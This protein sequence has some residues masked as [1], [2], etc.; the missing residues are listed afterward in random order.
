MFVK[1]ARINLGRVSI[2]ALNRPEGWGIFDGEQELSISRMKV[3]SFE[4]SNNELGGFDIEAA[5]KEHPDHLFVKVF[6]IKKDEVNDNG[7]AFNEEELKKS[8]ETFIGVPVFCNHQ[9]DDIEKARGKVVHAWY[10]EDKG[11]I[12]TINMVDKVAYPKLARGIEEGY[13]TGTSMGCQVHHSLCSICHTKAHVADEYCSHI[14]ERKTKKHS[15]KVKCAFHKSKCKPEEACPICGTEKGGEAAEIIHKDAVIHEWNYGLKFIEDSFV[16]NPACHDCLVDCILNTPKLEKEAAAINAALTKAAEDSTRVLKVADG[17]LMKIASF[18]GSGP[19]EVK[20]SLVQRINYVIRLANKIA[21]SKETQELLKFAGKAEI[22]SLNKAMKHMEVVAKS[23]MDQ[24]QQVSMEYVSDIVDVLASLQTV[25]DELVEMGYAALPTPPTFQDPETLSDAVPVN[26]QGEQTSPQAMQPA[27]APQPQ[28]QSQPSTSQGP[29]GIGS[30]TKPT[31]SPRASGN[32]KELEKT[33]ANVV[34]QVASLRDVIA[35]QVKGKMEYS[36]TKNN[37]TIVASDNPEGLLVVQ[38]FAGDKLAATVTE[39]LKGI[40]WAENFR[41][42]PDKEALD[43]IRELVANGHV[44][45]Q[46]TKESV[47][48]ADNNTK[49]AAG[50]ALKQEDTQVI[51]EK[52][53]NNSADKLEFAG[54][55]Q[56]KEI[57]TVT[58]GDEQLGL[59]KEPVNDTSSDSP[60]V[61]KG[62]YANVTTENQLPDLGDSPI[63]RWGSAPD[64]ILEKQWRD[65]DRL[66]G[67]EGIDKGDLPYIVTQTQLQQLRDHHRWVEPNFTTENQLASDQNWLKDENAWLNKGA[68]SQYA[69][70]LVEAA[71]NTLSDAIASYKQTPLEVVKAAKF[72]TKDPHSQLKAAFLTLINGSPA[73]IA[74]RQAERARAAYFDKVASASI[75]NTQ[76]VDAL[77]GCM[78][79]NCMYLKAEDLV[80]AVRHVASDP[81][82]MAAV[83]KRAQVKL[84]AK[85][86]PPVDQTVDKFAAMDEAFKSLSNETPVQQD[87]D[88]MYQ[89]RAAAEEIGDPSDEA[90]FILSAERHA[91]GILKSANVPDDTVL[92]SVEFDPES[93]TVLTT[94]KEVAKLSEAEVSALEKTA[95]ARRKLARQ[96]TVKSTQKNAQMMGG[97]MGGGMDGGAGAGGAGATMPPAPGGGAPGQPPMPPAETMSDESGGLDEMGAEEDSGPK[98][99]GAFCPVCGTDDVDVVG[100][101]SKCNNPECGQKYVVKTTIELDGAG[102]G[103]EEGAPGE[104]EGEGFE[105]PE[106]ETGAEEMGAE[107]GA[108]AGAGAGAP[109]IPVAAMT[110]LNPAVLKK[111]ASVKG[112]KLGCFSPITGSNNT[113]E[114]GNGKWLCLSS[115]HTYEVDTRVNKKNVS[116]VWAEWRWNST[117]KL[118]GKECSSCNRARA[119]WAKALSTVKLTSNQ[120]DSMSFKKKAETVLAMHAK[121]AFAVVKTASKNASVI[122]DFQK[123]YA[124]AGAFPMQ[125]C[126]QKLANRF[127]ENALAISGPCKGDKIFDCVC[128]QLKSAG[129]YSDRIAI[130][131]AETWADRDGCIECIEDYVRFGLDMDKAASVCQHLK[132]KYAENEE[133]LAEEM[134]DSGGDD[135]GGDFSSQDEGDDFGDTDPF[136]GGDEESGDDSGSPSATTENGGDD[137]GIEGDEGGEMGGDLGGEGFGGDAGGPP[138]IGGDMGGDQL[139]GGDLGA[140]APGG[141]GLGAPGGGHG[142]V[143]IELPLSAL[144]AIEQAI[145]SAHGE[146]PGAESHH[147]LSGIPGDT[148]VELQLDAPTVDGLEGAAENTLEDVSGGDGLGGGG[149]DAI[150]EIDTPG[151]PDGGMGEDSTGLAGDGFDEG[152]G[153][154]GGEGGLDTATDSPFGDESKEMAAAPQG[155]GMGAPAMNKQMEALHYMRKGRQNRVGEI[156][157]DVASLMAALNKTAG[158]PKVEPAQDATEVTFSAGDGSVQGNEEKFKA[159]LPKVPRSN[160]T[161]GNEASDANP[162]DKPLPDVPSDNQTIGHEEEQG[163]TTEPVNMTGGVGGAGKSNTTTSAKNKA[164]AKVATQKKTA[165]ETKVGPAEPVSKV[166]KEPYADG[167]DLESTPDKLKREGFKDSDLPEVPEKGEGAHIGHEVDQGS[168]PKANAEYLPKIPAGGGR[169]TSKFDKNEDFAPELQGNIKGTVIAKDEKSKA[170]KAEAVRIAGRMIEEKLIDASQLLQKIAELAVYEMPQLKDIEKALFKSAQKGLDAAPD[171]VEQP[172][173]VINEASNKGNMSLKDQLLS[174]SRL[175]QQVEMAKEITD[176]DLRKAHGR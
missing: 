167:K 55:R 119:A 105:L 10:D 12:W 8:A 164:P 22:D 74:K 139:G 128:N 116:E 159:D 144:D 90:T 83:E 117:P 148:E 45:N 72:I 81:V 101:Q 67:A 132:V 31:F 2:E 146:N 150:I 80:D 26:Q 114:L 85:E 143:T 65:F 175:N 68:A 13:I 104:Q 49:T 92:F 20:P 66:F 112:W 24:K 86:Q 171:G 47:A 40:P 7:D 121:D 76:A 147:D 161:I 52:A 58:E 28:P 14:K 79:D 133:L 111:M 82:K 131:V 87:S 153:A 109:S 134:S 54:K 33:G 140:P 15:G 108:G 5:V 88:G 53:L 124:F 21:N 137:A 73:K 154:P 106:G 69:G 62:E 102:D 89:V 6:A 61:R 9:N 44:T 16:V 173:P 78:G 30:V 60:Q 29:S 19:E 59:S 125:A 38:A 32:L 113:H 56:Y 64:V 48:M 96:A 4:K 94:M 93:E 37:V 152:A 120:F 46:Q 166:W 151:G 162:K 158:E 97:Q 100:G 41:K 50:S 136:S 168:V 149:P 34:K 163:Y 98:P 84:A 145:D 17:S 155:M 95:S 35:K 71:V 135:N 130:K 141:G 142:S 25:T 57:N 176:A 36:L 169:D 115:G 157:L 160:A 11:G 122:K 103:E 77:L 39:E 174:M 138:D 1:S 118:A 75:R 107:M 126:R 43:F 172:V 3:A 70:K 165:N 99:P 91:R 127:G 23:M 42:D 27:A 110:R 123:N 63:A 51:I 129:I 156:N 170:C 18:M